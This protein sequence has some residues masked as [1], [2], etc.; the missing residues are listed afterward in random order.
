M[1]GWW[2]KQK[3]RLLEEQLRRESIENSLRF[4]AQ[5]PEDV[6]IGRLSFPPLS[7][8]ERERIGTLDFLKASQ[9][10]S[11]I[12][13]SFRPFSHRDYSEVEVVMISEDLM[14]RY[15][16]YEIPYKLHK[17]FSDEDHAQEDASEKFVEAC[18]RLAYRRGFIPGESDSTPEEQINWLT[19]KWSSD[20]RDLLIDRLGIEI[21]GE[22][23][24]PLIKI[25]ARDERY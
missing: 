20:Y 19:R 16:L 1:F 17:D 25:I 12:T 24:L 23:L 5:K 4:G 6:L 22:E 3:K 13:R 10:F 9:E 7:E 11:R 14:R 21:Y 2:K 8:G 15:W 18:F